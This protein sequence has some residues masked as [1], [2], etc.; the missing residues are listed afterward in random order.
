MVKL[1]I[2]K[3]T[4]T[5][6]N[7][8]GYVVVNGQVRVIDK[9]QDVDVLFT[10]VNFEISLI[11]S[12]ILRSLK[13]KSYSSRCNFNS[14]HISVEDNGR[15]GGYLTRRCIDEIYKSMPKAA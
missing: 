13:Y 10:F 15:Y 12:L 9:K 7:K 4:Y 6:I 2:S 14:H 8:D 5:S 11:S 1:E 3:S